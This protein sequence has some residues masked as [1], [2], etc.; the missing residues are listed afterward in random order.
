[1]GIFKQFTSKENRIATDSAAVEGKP[2]ATAPNSGRSSKSDGFSKPTAPQ[3]CN[4]ISLKTMEQNLLLQFGF[5]QSTAP[6]NEADQVTANSA[7]VL[8]SDTA[9]QLF[10]ALAEL[11]DCEIRPN[12]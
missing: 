4:V 9:K 8:S 3:F 10:C 6:G 5:L 12:S 2:Y 11:F 7:V 1:M